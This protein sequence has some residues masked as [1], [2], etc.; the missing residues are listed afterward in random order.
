MEVATI[1]PIRKQSSKWLLAGDM[2]PEEFVDQSGAEIEALLKEWEY[3]QVA[4][5][6]I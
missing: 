1:K 2:T 3:R 6:E 5:T 4:E